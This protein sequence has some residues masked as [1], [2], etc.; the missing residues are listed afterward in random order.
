MQLFR[1]TA[2]HG[3]Y[4]HDP[5]AKSAP[6]REPRNRGVGYHAAR[7]RLFASKGLLVEVI[8]LAGA[9]RFRGVVERAGRPGKSVD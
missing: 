9:A 2:P 6:S 8:A 4:A 5:P 3:Q 1:M 7:L